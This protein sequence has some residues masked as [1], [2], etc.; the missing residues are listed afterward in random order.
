[1]ALF[2]M[3][4]SYGFSYPCGSWLWVVG[5]ADRT[6]SGAVRSVALRCLFLELLNLQQETS[7]GC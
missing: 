1:M 2:F 6:V 4:E 3:V 5:N 7:S